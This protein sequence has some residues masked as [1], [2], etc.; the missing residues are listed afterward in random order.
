MVAA[1]GITSRHLGNVARPQEICF[2]PC[3]ARLSV[4]HR[5]HLG[6]AP[7]P[8]ISAALSSTRSLRRSHL[9]LQARHVNHRPQVLPRMSIESRLWGLF[10]LRV[11][12]APCDSGSTLLLSRLSARFRPSDVPA[13][14]YDAVVF[15]AFVSTR[16]CTSA[17][18]HASAT[19]LRAH[20]PAAPH[21][22]RPLDRAKARLSGPRL[23]EQRVTVELLPVLGHTHKSRDSPA[24]MRSRRTLAARQRT[25]GPAWFDVHADDP[26]PSDDDV[27][28]GGIKPSHPLSQ[29]SSLQCRVVLPVHLQ[30][31]LRNVPAALRQVDQRG[32]EVTA[33]DRMETRSSLKCSQIVDAARDQ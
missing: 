23:I 4:P 9:E 16:C 27:P 7:A 6:P 10:G 1:I 26:V 28:P 5:A 17:A 21:P 8:T 24:A 14:F 32:H 22:R 29:P 18:S 20:S 33:L 15:A 3:R 25:E 2:S 12:Q 31:L 30:H 13:H 19:I 11:A